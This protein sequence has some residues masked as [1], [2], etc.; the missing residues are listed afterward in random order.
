MKLAHGSILNATPE[1][2]YESELSTMAKKEAESTQSL[3]KQVYGMQDVLPLSCS[4]VEA[5]SYY[6][7]MIKSEQRLIRN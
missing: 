1:R 7:D 6:D 2:R 5:L 4:G 3:A